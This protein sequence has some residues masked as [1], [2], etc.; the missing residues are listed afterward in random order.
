MKAHEHLFEELELTVLAPSQAALDVW[1]A[2]ASILAPAEVHEHLRISETA[3]PLAPKKSRSG[4]LR[5]AYVGQPV[6]HKGWPVFKELAV[7]FADDPRYEFFHV[8]KNPEGIPAT[9]KEVA[10]GSQDL[11]EMVRTLAELDV[12]VA[13]LW[14]LWPETFCIAA[15]EALRAGAAV[16]T[17]R[18]SGNVA[19]MVK[20]TGLGAVL[21]SEKELMALFESGKILDI[22]TETRPLGLTAEFSDMTADFLKGVAA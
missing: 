21:D 20:D 1:K 3:Q 5:V 16:V 11:N 2:S 19:A 4:P 12:D 22:V 15:V 6:T 10:V 13:L 18:D 9:F 7:S 14:S 8:G 17:F